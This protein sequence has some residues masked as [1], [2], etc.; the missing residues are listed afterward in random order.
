MGKTWAQQR[1][2]KFP[3][4]VT[5]MSSYALHGKWKHG[6]YAK[7]RISSVQMLALCIRILRADLSHM[8]VAGLTRRLPPGWSAYRVARL[9]N[10]CL[11]C[12]CLPGGKLTEPGQVGVD[13]AMLGWRPVGPAGPRSGNGRC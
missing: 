2:N 4:N 3:K 1:R 12:D 13:G 10:P 6:R 11:N 5:A 8:S 7:D 9:S